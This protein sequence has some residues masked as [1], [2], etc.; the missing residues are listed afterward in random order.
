MGKDKSPPKYDPSGD[1]AK[2]TQTYLKYLPQVLQAEQGF[3]TQ[4]D[5]KRIQEQ[6][7][8][9]A[10]YGPTQY[11]QQLD[12]LKQLDPQGVALRQQVGQAVSQNLGTEYTIPPALQQAVASQYLGRQIQGGN[13]LGNAAATSGDIYAGNAANQWYQ[14]NLANA[15]RFLQGPT[16]EQQL[17]AVQSVQPDRASAYVNPAAPAQAAQNSYQNMLAQYQASGGGQGGST[18]G[19]ITGLIGAGVAGY[20]TGFNPQAM[21][22]GYQTSSAVGNYFSDARLKD[23]IE[24][25]GRSKSGL[26]IFEFCYKNDPE[27]R[28][29]GTIAQEILGIRPDAV[30][31]KENGFYYVN[32]NKIDI[33]FEKVQNLVEA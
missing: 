27:N 30:T 12:A 23:H 8:L 10:K 4:Y 32:Y 11:Q 24:Y 9:Q 2:S 28:Y 33:D 5:P 21:Q 1:L 31:R 17:L 7:A 6:Q 13:V 25:I 15:Q 26:P 29:R 3:R 20:Y 19:A 16:P 14:Q 22:A 18:V